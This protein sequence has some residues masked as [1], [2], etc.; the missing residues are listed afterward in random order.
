[1]KTKLLWRACAVIVF[2]IL[3][4]GFVLNGFDYAKECS[5]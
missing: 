3:A 4:M 2:I 5:L 1:M